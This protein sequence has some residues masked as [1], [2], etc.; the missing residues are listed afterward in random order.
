MFAGTARVLNKVTVTMSSWACQSGGVYSGDCSSTPGSTFNMPITFN[1]YSVGNNGQ[2]VGSLL[3]TRTQTFAIPYRPTSDPVH[4]DSTAWYNGQGCF[5]GVAANI[6]FDFSSMHVLLPNDVIYG[7]Q[8]N[9]SGY[10]PHPYGYSTA[11]ATAGNCPYDSLNVG[12]SPQVNVGSQVFPGT[13]YQD[14]VTGGQYCDGGTG[15]TGAFRLDSP[16]NACWAGYVPAVQFTASSSGNVTCSGANSTIGATTIDGD[17]TVP[18]GAVCILNGTVVTHDIKVQSGGSLDMSGATVGHDVTA[19]HPKSFD[20]GGFS[21][22]GHDLQVNGTTGGAP[23]FICSTTVGH[24][25]TVQ[26]SAAAASWIIGDA[27]GN[28][29]ECGYSNSVGHDATIQNN[30]G[31]VD[32]SDNNPT[33]G[34]S[35]GDPSKGVGGIGHDLNVQN[36]TGASTVVES[37]KVGHNAGCQSNL[38]FVKDGDGTP[39]MAGGSNTC[40]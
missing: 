16:S 32:V 15:G 7:V 36:N 24:D 33:L 9:T 5:H 37:N 34:P 23:N 17:L 8:Y 14:S 27:G 40:S 28:P 38:H 25:L 21:T 30:A 20:T 19:D 31:S 4:C 3:A 13:A 39:N 12:L 10:G 6:T 1:V 18:S 2:S 22:I 35:S 29:S 11:C 26:G